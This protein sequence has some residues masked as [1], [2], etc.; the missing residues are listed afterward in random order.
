MKQLL[1]VFIQQLML[2]K[3]LTLL[4]WLWFIS[5]DCSIPRM[6]FLLAVPLLLYPLLLIHSKLL[7]LHEAWVGSSFSSAS[8]NQQFPKIS[9]VWEIFRCRV[10]DCQNRQQD[11]HLIQTKCTK[12]VSSACVKTELALCVLFINLNLPLKPKQSLQSELK[13]SPL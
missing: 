7:S 4:P 13:V 8:N 3:D 10:L 6:L 12:T 1:Q 5:S 11:I 9:L 2:N